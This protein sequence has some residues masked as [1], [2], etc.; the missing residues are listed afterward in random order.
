MTPY[1]IKLNQEARNTD[2][3][4]DIVERYKSLSQTIEKQNRNKHIMFWFDEIEKCKDAIKRN[5]N[6]KDIDNLNKL[7]ND[8]NFISDSVDISINK[9]YTLYMKVYRILLDIDERNK[10]DDKYNN[11]RS[12]Y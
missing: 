5:G 8:N 10:M 1:L 2:I 4:N 9:V 7:L 6:S 12:R 3:L 11:F